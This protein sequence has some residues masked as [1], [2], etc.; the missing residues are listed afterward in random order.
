[1]ISGRSKQLTARAI[2]RVRIVLAEFVE[3]SERKVEKGVILWSILRVL[4]GIKNLNFFLNL[5]VVD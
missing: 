5:I 1:M 4:M 3:V 2:S